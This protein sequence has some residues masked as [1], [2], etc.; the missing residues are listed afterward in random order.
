MLLDE[1]KKRLMDK[2]KAELI[3]KIETLDYERRGLGNEKAVIEREYAELDKKLEFQIRRADRV[4]EE[5]HS[6]INKLEQI[7]D[8][9]VQVLFPSVRQNIMQGGS[10][11]K[12]TP[13]QR[14][15]KRMI[16][17]A[18]EELLDFGYG[19]HDLGGEYL[20]DR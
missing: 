18:R 9:T 4:E 2:T 6:C 3:D 1:E 11:K 12:L 13:E 8:N 5:K 15:I 17:V 10:P 7:A 20:R 14:C 16:E 19:D